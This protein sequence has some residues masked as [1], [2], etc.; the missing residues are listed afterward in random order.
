MSV[1]LGLFLVLIPIVRSK[2]RARVGPPA[3]DP[4]ALAYAQQAVAAMVDN[5]TINDVT[6][7]GTI[8]WNGLTVASVTLRALRTLS[9]VG[10]VGIHNS[11]SVQSISRRTCM[12]RLAL[13]AALLIPLFAHAQ[14]P[15]YSDPFAVTLAQQSIAALTGG[16]T[17]SDVT[18]NASVTSTVGSDYDTGN[19]TFY[20]KGTSDSR[21]DFSLSASGTRS[22]VRNVV[23]GT[24]GGAWRTNGGPPTPFVQHNCWTDA[25]WF[26]PTFSS[27]SQT[28][29]PNFVFSY[30]A[31][32]QHGGVDTQHIRVYQWFPHGAPS[33]VLSTM[34][35]YL[36]ATSLLPVA[37][38][39]Q[40]HPDDNMGTNLPIE[41]DFTNYQPV[42]G[43][44]VPLHFQKIF[45]GGVVLD[46]TVTSASFNTGL[47]DTLFT[48]Q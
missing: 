6:L 19:A 26:F 33:A 36:D 14:N 48:L 29:N 22:D 27:L 11:R 3:S 44:Q 42:N 16:G 28:T 35:F 9:E 10:L 1:A 39:F 43:F 46:V 41:I 32:E 23:T 34:E 12:Y 40:S 2:L 31:R 18:L 21:V 5:A 45:G 15:P 17:L 38:G 7:N 37:I 25:P 8:R 30:I 47:S 4:Q 13:A 20:V 24:P